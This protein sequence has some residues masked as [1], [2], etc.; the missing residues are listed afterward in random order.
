MPVKMGIARMWPA[1][2]AQKTAKPKKTAKGTEALTSAGFKLFDKLRA[3]RMEI[4]REEHVPPYIIF[5]DKTLI[6][7]AAKAPA[8][9]EEMLNVSGVG[10]YKY[11]K[12]GTRF[13]SVIEE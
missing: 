8:S 7:M 9:R 2:M 10:E 13:L 6:D 3:L 5:S 1:N 11:A 12:Y 4:A